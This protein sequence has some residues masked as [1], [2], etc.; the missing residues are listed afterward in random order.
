MAEAAPLWW[1][2]AL[3]PVLA[4][5]AAATALA[6]AP[7]GHGVAPLR[8]LARRRRRTVAADA[9]LATLG[10]VLLPLAAVSGAV[11]LPLGFRSVSDLAVGVVWFNAMA[12]LAWPAVWLAGWGPNS[13]LS[14]IG[15]YRF[16][17]QG[18]A[19]EVP[20]MLALTTAALGAGSLR[21]GAVVEA[22]RGL[23]FVTWM[24][25]AF[26]VHLLSAAAMAFWGPF[27]RPVGRDVAGGAAGELGGADRLSFLGGRW[28]LLV[29]AAGMA[30]PLFLGGG[31]GP[32][33]PAWCWTLV[34]TAAVLAALLWL[35]RRLPA[36]RMDRFA[37]VAWTVVTPL[38]VAQA[39]VVAVVVLGR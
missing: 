19:Y 12:A 6:A 7:A 16:L 38:A 21:V 3:P 8:E 24:P 17:A 29:V 23:W 39:L 14:L 18:L 13:A 22:Q 4:V 32:L 11:V 30:V 37:A 33:L 36:V 28:L 31:H 1:A 27:D 9:P 10:A 15:G 20:H 34:K 2:L 5:A 26:A 35:R 25:V